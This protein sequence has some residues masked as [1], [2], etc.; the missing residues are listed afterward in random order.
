MHVC[1]CYY[2]HLHTVLFLISVCLFLIIKAI[3]WVCWR[4]GCVAGVCRQGVLWP[5][6]S[7][8]FRQ[9]SSCRQR[10]R[11]RG[12]HRLS[13]RPALPCPV[14][15]WVSLFP[16]VSKK[17][18][19]L[20]KFVQDLTSCGSLFC[21]FVQQIVK[22]LTLYTPHSDLDERVT[23]NF[24]RIVQVLPSA[25]RSDIFIYSIWKCVTHISY[26]CSS[27]GFSKAALMANLHSSWW[28]WGECFPS[29]SHTC[30]R[31]SSAP[32]S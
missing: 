29:H 23:L 9:F 27:R 31:P 16:S 4:S 6:W 20:N 10:K 14:S 17:K 7:P 32:S 18:K 5:H 19:K 12:M 11:Q 2:V 8:S 1:L 24:I 21:F 22:I 3:I 13:V 15:R 25:E 28:M 26:L 30:L